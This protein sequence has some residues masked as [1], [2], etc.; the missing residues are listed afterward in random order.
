LITLLDDQLKDDAVRPH[1]SAVGEM[2]L[3]WYRGQDHRAEQISV[4]ESQLALARRE[5]L[6][7]IIHNRDADDDVLACLDAYP[8]VTGVMHCFSSTRSFAVECLDRGFSISFAGNVTYKR[9]ESIREAAR[10]VPDDRLLL[11]TDAPFLAPQVVRGETNHPGYV[12]YVY[13]F[14]ADL[15]GVAVEELIDQVARNFRTLFRL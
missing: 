14:V 13:D 9:S 3:D 2:G 6:P 12:R 5:D 1:I 10:T 15:R 4:F 11:E 8:G 7:V